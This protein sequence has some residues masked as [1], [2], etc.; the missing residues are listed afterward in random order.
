MTPKLL[1]KRFCDWWF[2]FLVTNPY[3]S[4]SL[5]EARKWL[6]LPLR[7]FFWP[8]FLFYDVE[9]TK[10]DSMM[11]SHGQEIV[12]ETDVW[13]LG[14]E[15]SLCEIEELPAWGVKEQGVR[16]PFSFWVQTAARCH[17]E[18]SNHCGTAQWHTHW[19][20]VCWP[21]G[22]RFRFKF[23][24]NY[25]LALGT[26]VGPNWIPSCWHSLPSEKL[27]SNW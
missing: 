18:L 25:E 12:E 7:A 8:P 13:V 16:T 17:Q 21:C 2:V 4:A 9:K 1:T 27:L 23:Q 15:P 10:R 6:S 24:H 5:L 14:T 22:R 3:L 11:S 19:A 26:L 20:P